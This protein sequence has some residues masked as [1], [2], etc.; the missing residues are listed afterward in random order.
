MNK[1]L[2]SVAVASLACA[3]IME[4]G[5]YV[6]IEGGY[7][8]AAYDSKNHDLKVNSSYFVMPGGSTLKNTFK[9]TTYTNGSETYDVGPWK[10][11]NVGLTFG[12]EHFFANN[13]LGVRWGASA[14]F[15]EIIQEVEKTNGIQNTFTQYRG[16]IDAGLSFDLMVNLV[17]NDKFSFGIFGGVEGDYHYL[18]FNDVENAGQSTT[19]SHLSGSNRHSLDVAG[20]VGLSTLIGGH[21]R[22]DITAKLPVGYVAMGSNNKVKISGSEPVKT[23]FNFGYKYVF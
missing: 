15:T 6:G 19:K 20:R 18:V 22:F 1:R 8:G 21:H 16:Y 13:Y 3:S 12:S 9:S 17:S 10:G 7:T 4:A 23:S 14:G 5:F 11:F 2:L